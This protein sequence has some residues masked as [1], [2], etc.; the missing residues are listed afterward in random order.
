[1]Q[2]TR[3]AG[4]KT[5]SSVCETGETLLPVRQGPGSH[6]AKRRLEFFTAVAIASLCRSCSSREFSGGNSKYARA[7]H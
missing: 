1:M 5:V 3:S 7:R 4:W 2:L 6:T